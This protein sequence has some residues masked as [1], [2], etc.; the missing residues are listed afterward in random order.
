MAEVAATIAAAA[1]AE[2]ARVA[3]GTAATVHGPLGRVSLLPRSPAGVVKIARRVGWWGAPSALT[4]AWNCGASNA[5]VGAARASDA[6][7]ADEDDG[8]D[9]DDGSDDD[10]DDGL[11][12]GR[13]VVL[14]PP[15]SG[16]EERVGLGPDE[17]EEGSA[18][19]E[20]AVHS[21]STLL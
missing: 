8:D 16:A 4:R 12:S 21:P 2:L 10:N 1:A 6:D 7:D 11:W 13:L 9:N 20:S 14:A 18:A 15:C 17:E 3:L 5:A 19:W